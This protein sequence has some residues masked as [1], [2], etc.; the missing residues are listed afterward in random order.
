MLNTFNVV[1]EI[2]RSEVRKKSGAAMIWVKASDREEGEINNAPVPS[3][4]TPIL[5]IRIPRWLVEKGGEEAFDKGNTISLSGRLQGVRRVV[6][7]RDY[8]IVEA[9]ASY[10]N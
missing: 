8:F 4:F 9:Q 6:D 2:V 7:G 5:A 10:L 1:G 3:F